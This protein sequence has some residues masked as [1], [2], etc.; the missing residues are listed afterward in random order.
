MK[1]SKA[2]LV[3]IKKLEKLAVRLEELKRLNREIS[4]E[5]EAIEE[6]FKEKA[7]G[8]DMEWQ[9]D[10]VVVQLITQERT[11]LDLKKVRLKLGKTISQYEYTSE[12]QSF[13]IH[14]V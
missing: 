1:S 12:F 9:T 7:N 14:R 6:W 5:R 4:K 13:I 11:Y 10:T 8:K 3:R 2:V